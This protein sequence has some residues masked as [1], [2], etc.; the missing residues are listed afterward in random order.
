MGGHCTG[1]GLSMRTGYTK[2]FATAGNDTQYLRAFQYLETVL[3][4]IGQFGML[5]RYGGGIDY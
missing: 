2:S 5:L 3:A 1:S 4:E